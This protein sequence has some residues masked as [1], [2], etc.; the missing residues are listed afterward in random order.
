MNLSK[1]ELKKHVAT[2]HCSNSLSLLE[3]KISNAL[4][5]HAYAELLTVEE[6]QITVKELCEL[7]NYKGNN[8]AAIK[9]SLKR[10]IA[11][12]IEWNVLN[13]LTQE[14]DWSASTLLA[15]VRLKGP[16]CYYAYSPRMKALLFSP[17]MYGKINLIVQSHFKSNYGLALYENCIRYKGLSITR[18]FDIATF[19]NL[20]GVPKDKY[21][22][23]RDFKRRVIDKAVEEVNLYAEILI[24]EEYK[25][26]GREVVAI[27]FIINNKPTLTTFKNQ[28]E[29]QVEYNHFSDPTI[30]H[31]LTAIYGF[32]ETQAKKILNHYSEQT[33]NEKIELIEN[34]D[35]YRKGCID[36]MAAYLLSALKE[37]FQAAVSYQEA[38][39]K[40]QKIKEIET[41]TQ[42]KELA[43][44]EQLLLAYQQYK[45]DIIE[46]TLQ[47]LSEENKQIIENQFLENLTGNNDS[48]TLSRYQRYGYAHK[49]IK[50]MFFKF[51]LEHYANLF[52]NLDT[53]ED[54]IANKV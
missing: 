52:P 25:K 46:K 44:Q 51:L 10:L 50:A 53:F 18:W 1:Q 33:I 32:S 24:E 14:E 49:G 36:N 54:F 9:E 41:I 12:V 31:K 21:L 39:T 2:I 22:I 48:F 38:K 17:T 47:E 27:R 19:R 11:V 26:K 29:K 6:H 42:Q 8:H 4:L 3:R 35:S 28:E 13:E 40:Q 7:I 45:T 37:N 16:I 34:S 20:M 30:Y 23:F 15:S 43:K 5:H